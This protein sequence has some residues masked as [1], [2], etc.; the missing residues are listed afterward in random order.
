MSLVASTCGVT[1]ASSAS[2]ASRVTTGR[3]IK[4]HDR[5]QYTK[6]K[7]APLVFLAVP[8]FRFHS[9]FVSMAKELTVEIF[10]TVRRAE[11]NVHNRQHRT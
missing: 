5:N 6:N 8:S 2:H 9:K 7:Q 4:V 10:P 11:K 3:L 1:A